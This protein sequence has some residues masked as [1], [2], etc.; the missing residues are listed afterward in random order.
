MNLRHFENT[1]RQTWW[2]V[3]IDAW[4][5]SGLDRTN[6]C[7]QLRLSKSTFDRW[8]TYLAGKDAARQHAEYQ[9]ELRR[10]KRI[11]ERRKQR[12]RHRYAVSTDM[13]R[14]GVQAFWAMHVEAMNWSGMGVRE[15]AA[16]LQLS[17]YSLR[18]WRDRLD[19][20]EVEIDWRAH[21]HPSARPLVGTSAREPA[22]ES[23]LTSPP[24]DGPKA[25]ARPTR[26][27]FSDEDKRA[28]VMETDQPGASVSS[29]ARK[30][31]IVTGL[32][33]RW[34][35]QFGVAQKKRA[36]LAPVAMADGTPAALSLQKFVQ[37]PN[38]MM[39]VDLSDGRRVFAPTGSDPDDVRAQAACSGTAS[40]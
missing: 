11:E 22:S 38:G 9:A 5:Q 10:Q 25:P 20:G 26:R 12:V 17:S 14:R 4:R 34:R 2:R 31:G 21:L 23:R 30:H 29:V 28:I 39:A 33:F 16:A 18:L 24:D 13:R 35:V 36:K 6:Y 40:C 3:H 7:R 19:E 37:P 1:A 15:Y 32:L 8:L 27:F